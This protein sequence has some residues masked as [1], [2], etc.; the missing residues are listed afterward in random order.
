MQR[1]DLEE[2][3]QAL[4]DESPGATTTTALTSTTTA[5]PEVQ[6]TIINAPAQIGL[7]MPNPGSN[8]YTGDPRYSC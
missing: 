2:D 4:A 5:I 1:N 8:V 6:P 7:I 3:T